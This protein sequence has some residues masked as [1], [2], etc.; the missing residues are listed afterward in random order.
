MRTSS[1][2][3][4]SAVSDRFERFA[5]ECELRLS[6]EAI[7]IAPRDIVASPVDADEYF[8]VTLTGARAEATA[9]VNVA[10]ATLWESVPAI[11]GTVRGRG[12]SVRRSN[13][14]PRP[15]LPRPI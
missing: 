13:V 5:S 15:L 2:G 12:L 4:M 11:V 8:L 7:S 10:G 3:M 1:R 14:R 6:V 9:D